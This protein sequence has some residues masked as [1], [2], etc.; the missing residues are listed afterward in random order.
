MDKLSLVLP[1]VLRKRGLTRH[2]HGA[3]IAHRA[4]H[5]LDERLPRLRTFVRVARMQDGV[6]FLSCSHS[7]ALQECQGAADELLQFLHVEC[8][9]EPIKDIRVVRD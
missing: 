3:L 5:W 7:V 4:K 6:L 2:A 9:F 8:P 1:K